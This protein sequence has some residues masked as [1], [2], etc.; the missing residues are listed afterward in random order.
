MKL[1]DINYKRVAGPGNLPGPGAAWVEYQ[2][3]QGVVNAIYQLGQTVAEEK[4]EFDTK[5]ANASYADD[6][7]QFKREMATRIDFS[8][9][10]IKAMGLDDVVPTTSEE[11]G[12]PLDS[13]PK[14]QVY[15]I[16][17]E[18]KMEEARQ[19]Y[20]AG[21]A[22]P[23]YRNS[24]ES[25]TKDQERQQL[26]QAVAQSAQMAQEHTFA[27]KN[28]ALETAISSNQ[29]QTA[30][31]ILSDPQYMT[32]LGPDGVAKAKANITT[33]EVEMGFRNEMQIL[34]DTGNVKGLKEMAAHLRSDEVGEGYATMNDKQLNAWAD[35]F[36]RMAKATEMELKAGAEEGKER[37]RASWWQQFN[38]KAASPGGLRAADL[39]GLDSHQFLKASDINKAWGMFDNKIK[40]GSVYAKESDPAVYW[41]IS[42]L[43]SSPSPNP[44][45]VLRELEGSVAELSASDW[46][47]L[48]KQAQDLQKSPTYNN[49]LMSNEAI[50]KSA[51]TSMG[52]ETNTDDPDELA[53][54]TR[55]Q[56]S[57]MA[58]VE[59][60][61]AANN[62]KISSLQKQEIADKLTLKHKEESGQ[63]WKFGL[64][65]FEGDVYEYIQKDMDAGPDEYKARIDA[66][67]EGLQRRG[68]PVTA[69]NIL[70]I[71]KATK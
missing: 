16:A 61:Q 57:Y 22:S 34:S 58:E 19:K 39:A 29:F 70:Q 68:K 67:T 23:K 9:D 15:A 40:N 6:I 10:E 49:D 53:R 50:L 4:V 43:L 3:K 11:T 42:S 5:L 25:V 27:T 46:K 71:Y 69:E 45:D 28:V 21:I 20:G 7:S 47:S 17:L 54:L 56:R 8:P 33:A 18:R 1:P 2:S 51:Y 36:D 12:K 60:Q 44:A 55:F 30:R 41:K 35:Q 26:D 65:D 32:M 59:R 37:A 38:E 66:I 48:A 62:G 13:I 14:Y 64:G 63:W 52:L 31:E 24:W